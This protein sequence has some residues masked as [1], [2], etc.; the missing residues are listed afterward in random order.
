MHPLC[1]VARC[2]QVQ[3]GTAGHRRLCC[4]DRVRRRPSHR[5]RV[6]MRRPRPIHRRSQHHELA[7]FWREHVVAPNSVALERDLDLL[8]STFRVDR[9][10]AIFRAKGIGILD[11][12]K[13][14]GVRLQNRTPRKCRLRGSSMLGDEKQLRKR[15]SRSLQRVGRHE[16]V[17]QH[18]CG[19]PT[20]DQRSTHGVDETK[21]Q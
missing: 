20:R 2:E 11:I 13:D 7:F 12:L 17:Q 15:T 21:G 3:R 8:E 19:T 1:D 6:A 16:E 18:H 4:L 10:A 5:P 9:P 14:F